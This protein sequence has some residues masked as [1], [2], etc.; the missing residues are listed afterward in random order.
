[1]AHGDIR[2]GHNSLRTGRERALMGATVIGL[3]ILLI[4]VVSPAFA[5]ADFTLRPTPLAAGVAC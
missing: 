5:F 1:M 3:V 4:W 2:S